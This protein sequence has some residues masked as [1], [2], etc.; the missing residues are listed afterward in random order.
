MV[1]S[2]LFA[3]FPYVAFVLAVIVAG[4]RYLYDRFSY[5]SFS[6]QF[7]ENRRLFWASV[8][9]H[10]GILIILLGH[11]LAALLPGSWATFF[12]RPLRLYVLEVTA[13][14]LGFLTLFGIGLLIVR[15]LINPRLRVITTVMDWVLLTDLILQ[16]AS[17]VFI[18]LFYRWGSAWYLHTAVP[19]LWSLLC[20]NP[21]PQYISN[22]PFIT[23]F[24]MVNAFVVMALF[25]FS[26]LV[27]IFTVPVTYLWRPYQ[28]VIWNRKV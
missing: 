16:A 12:G 23:K 27:H 19:W 25:P 24:H 2:V 20:L 4:Y 9:W 14:T 3:S 26:Q 15:R 5:S 6:S 22:L 8:P 1:N 11:L 17:G 7:I 10:Y 13:L 21:Q 18:A 28:V